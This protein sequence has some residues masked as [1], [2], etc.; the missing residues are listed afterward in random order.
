MNKYF[1]SLVLASQVFFAQATTPNPFAKLTPKISKQAQIWAEKVSATLS[2]EMQ[3]AYLN[4]FA[5]NS[6]DSIP[7]FIKCA[8]HIESQPEMLALY[9]EL[10]LN[11]METIKKYAENVQ[12]KIVQKKNITEQEAETLW[13]KLEVKIQELVAYINGIYYH[14]LYS[15]IAKKASSSPLYMFD[16]KGIISQEKR[17]QSLPQPW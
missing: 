5:L 4:L 13:Q 15:V 17:T 1:V 7:A 6:E 10:G 9:E 2:E 12:G 11:I 16:D 8:E 14:A 3:L